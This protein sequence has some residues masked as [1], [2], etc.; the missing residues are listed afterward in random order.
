MEARRRRPGRLPP[1]G[2]VALGGAARCR[3]ASRRRP[4]SDRPASTPRRSGPRAERAPTSRLVVFVG[5]L[6]VSK[7]VDLL[8]AAWPLVR[9]AH[10]EARSRSPASASTRTGC[11]GCWRRSERG[12]LDDARE[13]A[14]AR[15]RARGRRGEAAADPLGLPR[16]SAAPATCEA[17]RGH[18]RLGRVR[19][20][21]RARRGRRASAGRRG[22]GDAEH[23][24]RGLR[25][26]R[27]RGRRLRRAAGLGRPLGDAARSR[28]SSPRRCRRRSAD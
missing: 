19:R 2:R 25:D 9:A 24:S 11:G 22:A 5:K 28:V 3:R 15:P 10:P 23:L 26:G 8:I 6:I 20:P 27:R 12:D 14:P 18:R 16:R 7:G 1:H 13:V 17:A 21:A 4:A